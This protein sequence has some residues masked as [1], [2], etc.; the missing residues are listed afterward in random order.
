[1]AVEIEDRYLVFTPP[2]LAGLVPKKIV[3]GYLSTK[4]GPTVRV[5]TVDDVD[6]YITIKGKKLGSMAP[7]YEYPIPIQDA[8]ELLIICGPVFLTKD[9]YELPGPDGRIWELDVFTG[10]HAG[11]MIAELELN[12]TGQ[13]YTRPWWLGPEVT[14]DKHMGNGS[15]ARSDMNDIQVWVNSY[16]MP[17]LPGSGNK[18]TP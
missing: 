1:M 14:S 5:R 7:E 17:P 18:P 10:R 8:R 6:A 12:Y 2:P 13:A 9:R 16:R 4:K 15:L 11:L 3:Q